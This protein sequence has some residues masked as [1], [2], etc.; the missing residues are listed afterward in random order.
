MSS[1]THMRYEN[2]AEKQFI[3]ELGELIPGVTLVKAF[4]ASGSVGNLDLLCPQRTKHCVT[5][6]ELC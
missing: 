1:I 6:L 3:L 4:A 5:N 2:V